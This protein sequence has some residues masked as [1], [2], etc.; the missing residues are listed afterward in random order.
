MKAG[1]MKLCL[2]VYTVLPSPAL[3]SVFDRFFAVSL[4]L[5]LSSLAS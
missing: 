3:V 5:Y 4:Y 1:V 2:R